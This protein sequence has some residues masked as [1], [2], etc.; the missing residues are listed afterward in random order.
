MYVKLL[1]FSDLLFFVFGGVCGFFV[2]G[3]FVFCF[4]PPLATCPCLVDQEV[5]HG[6]VSVARGEQHGG[7]AAVVRLVQRGT[8]LK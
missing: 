3:F 4:E 5:A 2:V 8:L 7:V 6:G 1:L